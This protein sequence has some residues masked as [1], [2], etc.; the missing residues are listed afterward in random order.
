MK[1]K[2]GVDIGGTFTDFFLVSDAGDAVMH[3]TRTV[4]W[5]IDPLDDRER[6]A[7]VFAYWAGSSDIDP[8][9]AE[10]SNSAYKDGNTVL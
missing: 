8:V 4:H 2:L 10:R 9:G 5:S 6:N 3:S 1:Y 7:M